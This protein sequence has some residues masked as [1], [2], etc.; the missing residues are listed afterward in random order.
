[1]TLVVEDL[2]ASERRIALSPLEVRETAGQAGRENGDWKAYAKQARVAKNEE[3]PMGSLALAF[4]KAMK[5][6]K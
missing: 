3:K 1:M 5:A 4:A 2:R 6:K